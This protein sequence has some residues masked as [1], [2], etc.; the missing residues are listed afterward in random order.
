MSAPPVRYADVM[1]KRLAAVFLLAAVA[2]WP[3]RGPSTAPPLAK[4]ES[5][6]TILGVLDKIVRE[7]ETYLN[8]P[9]PDGRALRLLTEAAGA[10]TIAEIG[11]STGYSGLWFCL[12]LQKTGGHLTT[13]E[14]DHERAT[15]ARGH[16]KEAGMENTVTVIEGDAHEQVAKLKGPLDVV[17]I[18]ADK[19]GYVDYLNKLL[20]LVRPGGLILAHN[21]DMTPDYVKAVTTSPDLETIFYMQGN[22]LGVTLKKR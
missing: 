7:H 10:K 19:G 8:V 11:T 14:I 17:F 16:F 6:K 15:I 2:A 18:D 4:T 13:F 20:P 12:A 5:E 21:I 3:Q 9:M 1:R 22:G